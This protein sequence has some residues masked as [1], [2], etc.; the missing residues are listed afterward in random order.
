MPGHLVGAEPLANFPNLA[1]EQLLEVSDVVDLGRQRIGCVDRENL[2][3]SLAVVNHAQDT[4]SLDS[5]HVTRLQHGTADFNNI[6]R[7][8]VADTVGIR[9]LH[10]RVLPSLREEAVVEHWIDSVIPVQNARNGLQ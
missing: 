2:P 3:V 10:V 1:W 7:V 8:A 4:Q 9:V 6:N 5:T